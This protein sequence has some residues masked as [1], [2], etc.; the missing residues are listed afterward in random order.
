ME[1]WLHGS[2]QNSMNLKATVASEMSVAGEAAG[3][4]AGTHATLS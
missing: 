1:Q 2:Q 3:D 4:G